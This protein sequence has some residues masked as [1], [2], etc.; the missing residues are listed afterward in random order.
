MLG[1]HRLVHAERPLVD[2]ALAVAPQGPLRKRGDVPSHL[3]R[4]G[5]RL[6]RFD[7][8]FGKANSMGF[9]GGYGAARQ[10]ELESPALADQPRQAHRA[11]VDQRYAEPAVEY[12]EGCVAGRDPEVAPQGQLEAACDRVALDRSE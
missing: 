9:L 4:F 5:Q 10:D 8:A 1:T 7:Q 11:E 12:T 6:A 2:H 3:L